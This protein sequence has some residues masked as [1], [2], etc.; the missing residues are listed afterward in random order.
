MKIGVV[1]WG[2]LGM[3]AFSSLAQAQNAPPRARTGFQM[4]L[5][6]GYSIPM[7]DAREGWK[8]SDLSSG[9]VPF[10]FDIGGKIIPEFF[11]GGYLGIAAGGAGGRTKTQCEA[12]RVDCRTL[13]V[14]IGIEAQYHVLPSE[15]FNPWIGYGF[16]YETI[17]L[18][19]DASEGSG[20][21]SGL[22]FA[23][24]SAGGD[25]RVSEVFGVGP[26]VDFSIG[27]Y[28]KA[29]LEEDGRSETSDIEK[30]GTHEWLTLGVRGV[31]FP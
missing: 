8:L 24:L 18:S 9:Q 3:C 30:T 16:G 27:K 12:A 26:F 21:L 5:R 6:T 13:G 29:T 11:L 10:I 20:N 31:L 2:L 4:A 28:S 25:F 15:L 1:V 19:T 22:Q 17:R 7:G 14:S 23:R